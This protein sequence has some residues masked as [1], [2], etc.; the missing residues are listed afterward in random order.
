MMSQTLNEVPTR[1]TH[2][3]G[4]GRRD[5]SVNARQIVAPPLSTLLR[6]IEREY[7]E[8][9]GLKLTEAQVRRFWALDGDTC[10]LVLT[11]L[12]ERRFLKCTAGGMYIRATG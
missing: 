5:R 4:R 10:S 12:L 11:A 9:P 7:R 1:T 6:R 2:S 3:T 8:M